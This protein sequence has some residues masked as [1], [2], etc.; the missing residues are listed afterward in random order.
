MT[1]AGTPTGLTYALAAKTLFTFAI[2]GG[3]VEMFLNSMHG[4]AISSANTT[5]TKTAVLLI[6]SSGFKLTDVQI[7]IT[8]NKF[9]GGAASPNPCGTLD[10]Q[11]GSIGLRACGREL[12]WRS[13]SNSRRPPHRLLG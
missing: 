13:K 2:S 8:S 7:G 4:I 1:T 3:S 6:D 11:A 12:L 5:I 10:T 9:T